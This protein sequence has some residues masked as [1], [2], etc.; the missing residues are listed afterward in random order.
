MAVIPFRLPE[1]LVMRLDRHAAKLREKQPG[2]HI[3]RADAL[4][5]LLTA[6]LDREEGKRG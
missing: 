6:A 1:D 5:L 3:T 2:L 4:R